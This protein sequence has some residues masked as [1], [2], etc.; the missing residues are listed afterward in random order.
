MLFQIY[1]ETVMYQLLG[2]VLVFTGLVLANEFARRTK[3]G[4]IICFLV[5]PAALTVY[6][7]AIA[8]GARA[9]AEWA[10]NNQTYTNMNSWFHYGAWAKPNGSR[11]SPLPSWPSIFSSPW[12]ATLSPP[13]T[14]PRL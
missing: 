6:F 12:P 10:L 9:G 8:I 11:C 14:A 2:F 3:T 7:I 4:G 5:L 13:S 1:G